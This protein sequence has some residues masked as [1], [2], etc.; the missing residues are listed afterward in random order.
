MTRVGWLACLTPPPQFPGLP[1]LTPT[2][3]QPVLRPLETAAGMPQK[4]AVMGRVG[5]LGEVG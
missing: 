1:A 2:C 3:P 4:V 5:G